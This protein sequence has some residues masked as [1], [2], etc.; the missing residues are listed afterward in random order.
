[1]SIKTRGHILIYVPLIKTST[2]NWR[3]HEVIE[4]IHGFILLLNHTVAWLI[5]YKKKTAT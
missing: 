2:L 3:H 4:D 1:M 5:R